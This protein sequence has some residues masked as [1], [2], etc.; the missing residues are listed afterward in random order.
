[1]SVIWWDVSGSRLESSLYLPAVPV[2]PF[3]KGRVSIKVSLDHWSSSSP[4]A[5]GKRVSG[6]S[7]VCWSE[8]LVML[9]WAWP[10]LVFSASLGV[11]FC[12]FCKIV[13]H[14]VDGLELTV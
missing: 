5:F 2:Y 7:G 8:G 10:P 1:M 3:I 9:G 14:V 13:F 6:W 4:P 11:L 12:F